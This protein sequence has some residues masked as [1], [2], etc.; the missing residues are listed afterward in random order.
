MRSASQGKRYRPVCVG[1]AWRD[2]CSRRAQAAPV[3]AIGSS[4]CDFQEQRD[5]C[6]ETPCRLMSAR[7]TCAQMRRERNTSQVIEEENGPGSVTRNPFFTSAIA[8]VVRWMNC[9][10]TIW[11]PTNRQDRGDPLRALKNKC[12]KMGGVVD[13]ASR[14]ASPLTQPTIIKGSHMPAGLF[15]CHLPVAGSGRWRRGKTRLGHFSA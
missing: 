8:A 3:A 10:P 13:A 12:N 2:G 11:V 9:S 4:R 5:C 14:F 15:W 6:H 7:R 1:V